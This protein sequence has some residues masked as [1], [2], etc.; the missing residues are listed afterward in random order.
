[1]GATAPTAFSPLNPPRVYTRTATTSPTLFFG[2]SLLAGFR[3]GLS[4]PRVPSA[5][6]QVP[7]GRISR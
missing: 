2:G 7:V 5:A 4:G 6:C 1:M 3:G